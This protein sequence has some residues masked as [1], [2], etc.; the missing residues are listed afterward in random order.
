MGHSQ[1]YIGTF[2]YYGT[3]W[4]NYCALNEKAF[5]RFTSMFGTPD[6]S[7]KSVLTGKTYFS[8]LID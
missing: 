4:R 1:P 5:V 7:F 2:T 8:Y 6:I 3:F